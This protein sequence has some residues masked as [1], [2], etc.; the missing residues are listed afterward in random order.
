MLEQI[1]NQFPPMLVDPD[2]NTAYLTIGACQGYW[3]VCYIDD[4]GFP[5]NHLIGEGVTIFD[6]LKDLMTTIELQ[7]MMAAPGVPV[8]ELTGKLKQDNLE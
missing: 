2:G 3:Q 7:R 1:L 6:S 4:D 5:V 8:D